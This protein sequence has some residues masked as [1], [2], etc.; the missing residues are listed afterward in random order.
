L[1]RLRSILREYNH[2]GK[3][4]KMNRNFFQLSSAIIL[5][6]LTSL[7]LTCA[8]ETSHC[9]AAQVK[10]Q[11]CMVIDGSGS[12]SSTEW[13]LIKQATAEAINNTIPHDGSIELTIVQFG[14]SSADGYART[15][16]HPTVILDA[17]YA[18]V[19]SQ[20]LAMPKGG[21]STPTAHGLYL[22]WEELVN[23]P[24]FETAKRQ[25]VNLATDGEPN[26]RNLNATTD[27]DQSGGS[28]NTED[29]VIAVVNN[30]V[31]QGL[32]ELDVEGIAISNSSI[33]WFKEWVVRPQPG[34][35]APPFTKAGWIRIVESPTAFAN[36]IGE[37]LHAITSG[38]QIWVPPVEGAFFAGMLSV[39]LASIVSSLSSAIVNPETY[40]I[41]AVAKTVNL[42]PES[43]K[44]WLEEF[45]AEKRKKSGKH[46]EGSLF[47][48]TKPETFSYGVC[49]VMLT[50]AFSYAETDTL[51]GIIIL[52]PTVL[53]TAVIIEFVKNYAMQVLAR[54]KK[55]WAEYR[56]WYFGLFTF[57]ISTMVFKVPFSS[58]SILTYHQSKFTKRSLGLVAMTSIVATLALASIFYMLLINGSTALGNVGLIMCLMM[59]FFDTIPVPPMN[60]KDIYDWSKIV[61]VTLFI[62]SFALYALCLFLL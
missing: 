45:A 5:I 39:G 9:A 41:Q 15:E 47:A 50:F 62:A 25:V 51:D 33:N 44:K 18:T 20:V 57:I 60:G 8:F 26:V 61:W 7:F 56:L 54:S 48:L 34:I 11:V 43:L 3:A 23:S 36:T 52:I 35:V 19:A 37:K 58:P 32:D 17:N 22:G 42:F 46:R 59:A 21:Q 13:D 16:I 38:E 49:L 27:L 6:G 53:A 31:S 2:D 55:A 30:A 28:P 24:N 10:T 29:D 14:Y 40:P 12:I 1:E 4:Q